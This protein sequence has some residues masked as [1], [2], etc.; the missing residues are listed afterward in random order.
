MLDVQDAGGNVR[1]ARVRVGP[2]KRKHAGA[3]LSQAACSANDATDRGIATTDA[4]NGQ[5]IAIVV[6]SSGDREQ[7]EGHD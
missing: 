5:Q 7:A 6:D 4:V 1:C 3:V 2:R